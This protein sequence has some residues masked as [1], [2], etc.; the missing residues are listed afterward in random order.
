MRSIAHLLWALCAC[1]HLPLM[2]Q[3][4]CES[5]GGCWC[6]RSPQEQQRDHSQTAPRRLS[7]PRRQVVSAAPELQHG[8]LVRSPRAEGPRPPRRS[9][10][11]PNRALCIPETPAQTSQTQPS[12]LPGTPSQALCGPQGADAKRSGA[13]QVANLVRCVLQQPCLSQQQRRAVPLALSGSRRAQQALHQLRGPS[14]LLRLASTVQHQA[15]PT[16]QPPTV[17]RPLQLSVHRTPAIPE[18]HLTGRLCQH[19]PRRYGPQQPRW[20]HPSGLRQLVRRHW[21]QEDRP[22]MRRWQLRIGNLLAMNLRRR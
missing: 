16:V 20:R 19:P 2:L 6:T 13:A 22:R 21:R 5:L 8:P 17:S 1:P 14:W 3:Q 4:A 18:V 9:R 10:P 11:A 15:N 7:L 12:P